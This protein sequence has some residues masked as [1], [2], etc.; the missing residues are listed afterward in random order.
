MNLVCSY[1]QKLFIYVFMCVYLC[2]YVCGSSTYWVHKD[3][4]CHLVDNII[5]LVS[6]YRMQIG[7]VA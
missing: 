4:K 6:H 5:N 1:K 7:E 2:V 3:C